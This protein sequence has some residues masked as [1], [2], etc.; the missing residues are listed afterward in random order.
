MKTKIK[1]VQQIVS[2]LKQNNIRHFVLS[3]GTRHVAFVHIVEMDPFFRCYSIVDERSAAF[4]A[5]GLSEALD[6][7][8]GFACTSATASCNYCL[9]YTS[10]SPRDTR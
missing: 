5:L 9:L 3:P 1:Q 2:L 8:V 10:P 7:P 4:F 6:E